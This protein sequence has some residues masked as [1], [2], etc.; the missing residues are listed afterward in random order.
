[1][2]VYYAIRVEE[3]DRMELTRGVLPIAPMKPLT[4]LE[5]KPRV[6][7]L[8]RSADNAM[9]EGWKVRMIGSCT[10]PD[11]MGRLAVRSGPHAS[12]PDP[13]PPKDHPNDAIRVSIISIMMS[14]L[15]QYILKIRPHQGLGWDIAHK[16]SLYLNPIHYEVN[17]KSTRK[18]CVEGQKTRS[19]VQARSMQLREDMGTVIY[20]S[21][22]TKHRRGP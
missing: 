11:V 9:K 14:I 16:D 22:V 3:E 4:A 6:N 20:P 13:E 18:E 5:V 15:S 12:H 2:K 8:S 19:A 17:S 7:A 10:H 1:M 21:G